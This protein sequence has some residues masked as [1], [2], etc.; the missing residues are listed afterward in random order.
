MR[1]QSRGWLESQRYMEEV[2]EK[3]KRLGWPYSFSAKGFGVEC[4][5]ARWNDRRTR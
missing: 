4:L 2:R 5:V 1:A 3:E